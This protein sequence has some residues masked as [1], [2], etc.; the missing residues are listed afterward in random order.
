MLG[1][2]G[3]QPPRGAGTGCKPAGTLGFSDGDFAG[4]GDK[5]QP[6]G[7]GGTICFNSCI[8]GGRA[9]GNACGCLSGKKGSEGL[10]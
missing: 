7:I 4:T 6:F 2:A 3:L 1:T 9:L 8:Q 10:V 5:A